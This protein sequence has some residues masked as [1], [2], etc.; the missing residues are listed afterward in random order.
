VSLKEPNLSKKN[1][2]QNIKLMI[3]LHL[4]VI[5]YLKKINKKKRVSIFKKKINELSI[6]KDFLHKKKNFDKYKARLR[7]FF[8]KRK[9]LSWYDVVQ[10]LERLKINI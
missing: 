7:Y 5:R 4:C 2:V 8:S 1:I 10:N 9:N 3:K 6:L